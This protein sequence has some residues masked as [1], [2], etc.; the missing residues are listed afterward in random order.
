MAMSETGDK[1]SSRETVLLVSNSYEKKFYFNPVFDRLPEEI[2]KELKILS[3]VFTEKAGGILSMV[4]ASDGT[5]LIRTDFNE[6][7]FLYDEI[8]AGMLINEMQREKQELFEELTLF[9][10]VLFLHM[11]DAERIV[12][13]KADGS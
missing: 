6:D 7:D 13:E 1:N 4:Y 5:L 11:Y 10:K 8:Y 3:V 9:Y 12:T 2:K